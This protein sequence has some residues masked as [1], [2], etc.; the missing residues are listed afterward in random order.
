M[1]GLPQVCLYSTKLCHGWWPRT[2]PLGLSH[3]V[4]LFHYI[5][6]IVLT[7]GCPTDLE[8][9]IYNLKRILLAWGWAVNEG[10]VQ[11]PC[12][13]DKYLDII[14]SGKK[15]LIAQYHYA[16]PILMTVHQSWASMSSL[17]FQHTFIP[18]LTTLQHPLCQIPG[19]GANVEPDRQ[20]TLLFWA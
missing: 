8:A 5:D 16:Y 20:Q 10:K 14:W 6:D 9:T 15:K 1:K 2:W 7:S 19:K 18:H 17:S 3:T 11:G 4:L 12:L 13:S